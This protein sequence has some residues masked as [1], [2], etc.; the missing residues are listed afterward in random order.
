MIITTF[1]DQT[2]Q[3]SAACVSLPSI[4][5]VKEP[6]AYTS[7]YGDLLDHRSEKSAFI[8]LPR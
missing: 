3:D 5:L 8:G 2:R 4:H 7:C 1:A 6:G